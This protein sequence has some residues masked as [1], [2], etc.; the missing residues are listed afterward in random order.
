M[1]A[2]KPPM[3]PGR[4]MSHKLVILA[5]QVPGPS[6]PERAVLMA[7]SEHAHADG[8]KAFPS[9][10]LIAERCGISRRT[11]FNALRA[12]EAAG[13]I[14]PTRLK[15]GRNLSNCYSLNVERMLNAVTENGANSARFQDP[16]RVQDLP[17]TVQHLHENGA[18]FAPEQ[19][20]MNK[21]Q[22]QVSG[23]GAPPTGLEDERYGGF[24]AWARKLD[25]VPWRDGRELNWY[26]RDLIAWRDGIVRAGSL[27]KAVATWTVRSW[28]P[29]GGWIRDGYSLTEIQK[30]ITEQMEHRKDP[31]KP[32]EGLAFFNGRIREKLK[33]TGSPQH[34]TAEE[35]ARSNARKEQ[36]FHPGDRVQHDDKGTGTVVNQREHPKP[37]YWD[38]DWQGAP[39]KF[40]SDG[41]V[42]WEFA[43]TIDIIERGPEPTQVAPAA[44]LCIEDGAVPKPVPTETPPIPI[45]T[46]VFHWNC[47]YG[48]VTGFEYGQLV[49][50]FDK[51][52]KTL[53]QPAECVSVHDP[54]EPEDRHTR[55]KPWLPE[56]PRGPLVPPPPQPTVGEQIAALGIDPADFEQTC[57]ERAAKRERSAEGVC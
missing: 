25:P 15:G 53:R 12:L 55:E 51:L 11:V 23:A 36:Q 28:E 5:Y 38:R 6:L 39:I 9:V 27:W 48:S 35:G 3:F 20:P 33:P 30:Q 34:I 19:V 22:Y 13:W 8:T 45:G 18:A 4:P 49:V 56:P 24:D 31:T 50:A 41:Q 46:R 7:V 43:W 44:P 54:A 37:Y 29:L 42:K 16:E 47:G 1:T 14:V 2:K 32:V 57:A 10:D 52:G 17:E 26:T 21:N 40:D